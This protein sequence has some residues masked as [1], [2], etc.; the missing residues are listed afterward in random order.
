MKKG[1][2]V[3]EIRK[4]RK[5]YAARFGYELRAICTDLKRKERDCGHPIVSYPPKRRLE[6]TGS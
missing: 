4:A 1:P 3:E 2:I 6:A 5:A